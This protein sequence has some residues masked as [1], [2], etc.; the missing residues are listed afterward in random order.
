MKS[1]SSIFLPN[2]PSKHT[3][4]VSRTHHQLTSPWPPPSRRPHCRLLQIVHHDHHIFN[5]ERNRA[6]ENLGYRENNNNN[7][8]ST[9]TT[10]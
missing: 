7:I 8:T 1:K 6:R 9:T 3:L 2:P 5:C 10:H 4:K